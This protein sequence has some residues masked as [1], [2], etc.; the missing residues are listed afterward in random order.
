MSVPVLAIDPGNEQSAWALIDPV[1][2][3]PIDVGKADNAVVRAKLRRVEPCVPVAIEMIASYGMSV[4]ATVLQ[5]VL[6][7]GRFQEIREDATLVYRL[8]VKLH[9]CHD[10]RANDANIT[11]ALIDRFACGAA[12]R[13]KG[14]KK[15]PGFFYGFSKDIWQAYALAVLVADGGLL[16]PMK[17]SEPE[18][19][20]VPG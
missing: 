20:P 3:R 14:T 16:T 8:D 10:S 19:E 13:G 12:N 4:G 1:T 6:A 2:C 18:L 15:A 17:G 7:I 9:H 5:T 11:Q